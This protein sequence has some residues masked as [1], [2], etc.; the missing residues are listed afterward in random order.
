[1]FFRRPTAWHIINVDG[2][3]VDVIPNRDPAAARV[4]AN[5]I[6]ETDETFSSS[7]LMNEYSIAAFGHPYG[8]RTRDRLRA[9]YGAHTVKNWTIEHLMGAHLSYMPI[10]E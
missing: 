7:A 10:D 4:A 6:V 2:I 9:V 5:A 8:K 1:M 3:C